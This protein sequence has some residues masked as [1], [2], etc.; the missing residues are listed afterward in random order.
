MKVLLAALLALLAA[1]CTTTGEEA[2][3][4]PSLQAVLAQPDAYVG[5]EVR[6][7]GTIAD[8]ENRREETCLEV[9]GR[10]LQSSGRPADKDESAGRFLACIQEFLDP[11]IYSEG[12]SVTVQGIVAGREEGEVGAYDYTYPVVMVEQH[13]LWK[14][15]PEPQQYAPDPFWYGPGPWPRFGP[16]H[17]Y[18]HPY[19]YRYR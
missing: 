17:F 6:W 2:P 18:P 3:A 7:G 14:P 5:Q 16:W 12:R 13:R 9:V 8:V 11:V 10:P 15:R 1:A 4:R 19:Y